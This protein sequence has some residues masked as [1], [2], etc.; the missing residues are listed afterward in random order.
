MR[1]DVEEKSP[2]VAAGGLLEVLELRAALP[3]PDPSARS[4]PGTVPAR[5]RQHHGQLRESVQHPAEDQMRGGE[6]RVIRIARQ[7]LRVPSRGAVRSRP[8]VSDRM[9]Q[10]GPARCCSQLRVDR[11]QRLIVQFLATETKVGK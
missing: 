6:A 7:V 3:R 9:Q 10:H 1:D 8:T 5:V 4:L 2:Q 11:P